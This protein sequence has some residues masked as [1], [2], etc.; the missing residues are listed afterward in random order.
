MLLT[1]SPWFELSFDVIP[2]QSVGLSSV[3]LLE[4]F[5]YW[6]ATVHLGAPLFFLHLWSFTGNRLF[7]WQVCFCFD[8]LWG[9]QF[10]HCPTFRSPLFLIK[11]QL[12]IILSFCV[13]FSFRPFKMFS[14]SWSFNS[15]MMMRQ[16][17][18]SL[19]LSPLVYWI[20]IVIFS[21]N[22]GNRKHLFFQY[23]FFLLPFFPW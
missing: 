8:L 19:N 22:F 14:F 6:S 2:F 5:C 20:C 23:V 4:Y 13:Q 7:C 1:S 21:S 10:C 9:L 12:L 16:V 17:W 3:A 11:S 15:L 18:V